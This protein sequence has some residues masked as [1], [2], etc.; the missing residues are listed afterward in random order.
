MV[1]GLL[2]LA[3]INPSSECLLLLCHSY[4]EMMFRYKYGFF[5]SFTTYEFLFIYYLEGTMHNIKN[6][7][8]H[9]ILIV[10][11]VP[12]NID[13]LVNV[14]TPFPEY[15]IT[16][17][18]SGERALQLIHEKQV[19]DLLLLDIMMPGIDGYEVCRQLKENPATENID[20]IFVSAKES[21]DE[22][23]LGY[24]AGG[25]DYLTK[26]INPEEL[27]HKVKLSIENK[28]IS[29]GIESE[30]N[31]AM[32]TAMTAIT[33]AGELGIVLD[34]MRQSNHANSLE[35]LG[36]NITKSLSNFGLS[37]SVQLRLGS[38][39]INTSSQEPMPPLEKKFLSR[40][41]EVG[42]LRE[43]GKRLI[44]NFDGITLLVKNMPLEAPDKCGR[45]RDHIAHLIEGAGS[46]LQSLQVEQ[47]VFEIIKDSK[48]SLVNVKQL[49]TQYKE[50]TVQIMDDVMID[51]ERSFM[52]FGLTEEQEDVLLEVIKKGVDK[53]LDNMEQSMSIDD[54]FHQI[55]KN[56]EHIEFKH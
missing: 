2:H 43:E 20:V 21:P 40:V 48:L 8:E 15:T 36:Q 1:A 45:L 42:R 23:I 28:K 26:P 19:P 37:S 25:S 22:I 51:L 9:H 12:S 38:K 13:I 49:Q 4:V 10:D 56:L 11:D 29:H 55:I 47:G 46:R 39:T 34:F 7:K 41:I 52:Q 50:S 14:L 32:L 53:S 6:S 18:N 33:N 44:A 17:A 35:T 16:A 27:L 3:L 5:I 31:E 30:K 24:E 54:E